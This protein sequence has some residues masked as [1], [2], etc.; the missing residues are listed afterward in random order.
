[1]HNTH[2]MTKSKS[3]LVA[4]RSSEEDRGHKRADPP[5][6][7]LACLLAALPLIQSIFIHR[8]Q[9]GHEEAAAIITTSAIVIARIHPM[10]REVSTASK[11]RCLVAAKAI[12]PGVEVRVPRKKCEGYKLPRD[13]D[14]YKPNPN[15]QHDNNDKHR[16]SPARPT[17]TP[18]PPPSATPAATA[19]SRPRLPM[20]SPRTAAP[21]A[22]GS[23][24]AAGRASRRTGGSTGASARPSGAWGRNRP[25]PRCSWRRASSG[26]S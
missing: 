13:T 22:S 10:W 4:H 3:A 20:P 9:I 7:L 18:S 5:A 23:A 14:T 11:G 25:A 2:C 12:K 24:T 26:A 15:T 16:S 8:P 17:P 21:A 1:M 6:L 19:A